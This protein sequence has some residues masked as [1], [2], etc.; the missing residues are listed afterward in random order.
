[1]S[2]TSEDLIHAESFLDWKKLLK[3]ITLAALFLISFRHRPKKFERVKFDRY[4]TQKVAELLLL[5]KV[6]NL[7]TGGK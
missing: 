1:M 2:T 6:H 3:T 7:V 4:G 5:K